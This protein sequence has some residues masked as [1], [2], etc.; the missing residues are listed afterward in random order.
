MSELQEEI[1]TLVAIFDDAIDLIPREDGGYLIET[2]T[3]RPP[4]ERPQET[5]RRFL[6]LNIA[7]AGPCC[8]ECVL[9]LELTTAYPLQL[10]GIIH[11]VLVD[12]CFTASVAEFKLLHPRGLSEGQK[13]IILSSLQVSAR[14][15]L[16]SF[17]LHSY[18]TVPLRKKPNNF[19]VARWSF[20]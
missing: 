20:L 9:S 2:R 18:I 17:K 11:S 15:R 19:Q 4:G 6:I 13:T 12:P 10:P 3:L 14:C 8:V 7:E 1:E 5:S 16:T